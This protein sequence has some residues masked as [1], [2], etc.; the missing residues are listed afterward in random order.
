[1]TTQ[2]DNP[3][4][5]DDDHVD[6]DSLDGDLIGPND[7]PII[8]DDLDEDHNEYSGPNKDDPNK[9]ASLNADHAAL[10]EP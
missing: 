7:E 8:H 1:M 9:H 4:S 3:D 2:S 6:L 5:L 10:K